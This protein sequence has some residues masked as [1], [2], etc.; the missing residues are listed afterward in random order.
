M[1]R[2]GSPTP[3]PG[4]APRRTAPRPGRDAHADRLTVRGAS[5][6]ARPPPRTG[7]GSPAGR[8]PLGPHQPTISR[9]SEAADE[10]TPP[11]RPSGMAPGQAAVGDDS[12]AGQSRP[13]RP[14]VR[15]GLPRAG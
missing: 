15:L 5:R 6:R 1:P 2:F 4:G 3:R 13:N 7:L 10:P 14:S 8:G 9:Y 11:L 12:R